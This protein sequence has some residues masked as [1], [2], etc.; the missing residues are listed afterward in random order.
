MTI[1]C[2]VALYFDSNALLDSFQGLIL[3][4]EKLLFANTKSRE[5]CI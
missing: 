2:R 4:F 3:N 5:N 1:V